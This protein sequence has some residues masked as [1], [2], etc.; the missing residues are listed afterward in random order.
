MNQRFSSESLDIKTLI[1]YFSKLN[2][3]VSSYF[4]DQYKVNITLVVQLFFGKL[5]KIILQN[6]TLDLN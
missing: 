1:N 4:V 3:E 6:S 5:I 2:F